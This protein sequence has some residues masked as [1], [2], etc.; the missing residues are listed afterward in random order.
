MWRAAHTTPGFSGKRWF[1]IINHRQ[2]T[3]N[4]LLLNEQR[5]DQTLKIT[6]RDTTKLLG[7]AMGRTDTL[8]GPAALSRNAVSSAGLRFGSSGGD[9]C[10]CQPGG[11][12]YCAYRPRPALL[13][14]RCSWLGS[15]QVP[16]S[17]SL[18]EEEEEVLCPVT[19][20]ITAHGK[21]N[22]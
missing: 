12:S 22:L 4:H 18:W 11:G 8:V 15:V 1:I 7:Q 21:Q 5:I 2:K 9:R 3:H 13:I 6:L 20:S 10:P 14:Q 16:G 17:R 19:K